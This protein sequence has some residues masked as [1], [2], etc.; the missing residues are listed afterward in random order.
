VGVDPDRDHRAESRQRAG[1]EIAED[2]IAERAEEFA[3]SGI[4]D[5]IAAKKGLDAH[6][7]SLLLRPREKAA[8]ATLG[9]RERRARARP[10]SRL[11]IAKSLCDLYIFARALTSLSYAS[12][13]TSGAVGTVMRAFM[14]EGWV[15]LDVIMLGLGIGF[16]ALSVGYAYACEQA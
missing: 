11:K 3:R 7:R 10:T 14:R 6:G 1:G 9:D 16:F 4:V 5:D 8:P 2:T 12:P 13:D 15:M